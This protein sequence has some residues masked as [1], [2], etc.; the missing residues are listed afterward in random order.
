MKKHVIMSGMRPTG[1]LHM[2]NMMGALTNWVKLQDD[3]DC[4]FVVVDWHAL[5]TEYS[6]TEEIKENIRQ[7]VIDWVSVGLDP[8]KCNIFVQSNVKQHAELHLLFSMITPL[9]WLERCPTYKEQL[10]QLE[11]KEINTYGF[12]GYPVLMA[13]DIL[14]YKADR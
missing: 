8:E 4:Y 14:I 3:Y 9:S 12:L 2:G 10:K 11:N 5:T 1:R 7:M 13:T 6:S